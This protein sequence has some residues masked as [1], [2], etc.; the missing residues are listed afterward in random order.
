MATSHTI[1]WTLTLMFKLTEDKMSG[2]DY[3]R[4]V[5]AHLNDKQH[6]GVLALELIDLL[7][8]GRALLGDN[9]FCAAAPL[10]ARRRTQHELALKPVMPCLRCMRG[11]CVP[12]TRRW[13]LNAWA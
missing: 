1:L 7:L 10:H 2:N 9:V 5:L 12:P 8:Q 6:A 13:L 3:E 4:R 11:V